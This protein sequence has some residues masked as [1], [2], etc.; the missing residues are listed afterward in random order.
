VS[1][2]TDYRPSTFKDFSGNEEIKKSIT[3]MLK[4]DNPPSSFMI[5]GPSGAGKTTLARIIARG[6]KCAKSDFKE[7]NT[8]NDRTLPAIRSIISSMKYA[9]LKGNK[10]VILLDEAHMLLKP[11]QEALLKALEEPPSHVHFIICTTNPEALRTTFK[12][13]CHIY[14]VQLLTSS[15]M[16]KLMKSILKKEQVKKHSIKVFDKIVELSG[17]SAGIALK[18]LDMVIDMMDDEKS[19]LST[20]K[21]AGTTEEDMRLICQALINFNINENSRWARVKSL[22]KKMNTD[23]ESARRPILGYLNKVLLNNGGME[24]AMVMDEFKNNFYDSG[25]SGLTLACYKAC[26]IEEE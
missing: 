8:A 14:E 21:A 1:L 3:A 4:R 16:I 15:E 6:L 18:Y 25:S 26:F 22:L 23:G 7:L 19:A 13:R 9:P 5:I 11:P 17:G 10:K 12:R 24:V 2:Q 20:L